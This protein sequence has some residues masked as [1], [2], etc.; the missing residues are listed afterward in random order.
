MNKMWP[1]CV[2][3]IRGFEEEPKIVNEVATI[4]QELDDFE[5]LSHS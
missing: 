5:L 3:D 1:E 4:A 2:Y